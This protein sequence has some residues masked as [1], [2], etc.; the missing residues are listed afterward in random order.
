MENKGTCVKFFLLLAI[1]GRCWIKD[2]CCHHN[3]W[4]L[5]EDQG[6]A[7]ENSMSWGSWWALK[8]LGFA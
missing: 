1:H 4:V 6:A 8:M 3:L 2:C 7:T 5:A